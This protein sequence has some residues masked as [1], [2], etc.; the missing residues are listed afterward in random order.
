MVAKGCPHKEGSEYDEIFSS[1]VKPASVI[2]ILSVALS[3]GWKIHQFDFNNAFLNRD[4][5]EEVFMHLP[6]GYVFSNPESIC[7][8]NKALYGLKQAPRA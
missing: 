4:L 8:L 1:V 7:K 2:L 5:A 6:E 3:K